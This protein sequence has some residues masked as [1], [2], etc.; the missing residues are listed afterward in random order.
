MFPVDIVSVF[1][2]FLVSLPLIYK[3]S[4]LKKK[5]IWHM[6]ILQTLFLVVVPGILF[7]I[8]YSYLQTVLGRPRV[9]NSF[10]SDSTLINLILLATLFTY[11]GTAIHAVTKMLSETS[12]RYE[13][14]KVAELNSYFHLEFSHNLIY[15]GAVAMVIG[16]TLLEMNH[17][18]L[19]GYDGLVKPVIQGLI[20]GSVLIIA[21]LHYTRSDDHYSGRWYDLKAAFLTIWIGLILILYSMWRATPSLRE[22]QL[23]VPVFSALTL[24]S[25]LNIGLIIR[26]LRKTHSLTDEKLNS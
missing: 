7:I 16:M 13:K 26:R 18:P 12:L 20:G 21:M 19:K 5:A 2:V 14:T 22:Y 11:G 9:D 10:L 6:S 23:V 8:F 1:L 15:S 17:A 25:I 24:V 3:T 4:F